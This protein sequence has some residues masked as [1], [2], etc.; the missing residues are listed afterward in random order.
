MLEKLRAPIHALTSIPANNITHIPSQPLPAPLKPVNGSAYHYIT[1][2][3]KAVTALKRV[4]RDLEE[5]HERAELQ[6][7]IEALKGKIWR[8]L[9]ATE[10]LKRENYELELLAATCGVCH[11]AFNART[12][13]GKIK[14]NAS[15][16]ATVCSAKLG[17]PNCAKRQKAQDV[18]D[19]RE[20]EKRSATKGSNDYESTQ[21]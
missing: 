11:L 8:T 7:E 13:N 15:K 9:T 17:D 21:N 16:N 18:A 14:V 1:P 5:Q 4:A 12:E 3:D 19:R 6:R 20:A 10:A 2:H